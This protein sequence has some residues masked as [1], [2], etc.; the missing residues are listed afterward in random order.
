M[1]GLNKKRKE[2]KKECVCPD[3]V[4]GTHQNFIV[5]KSSCNCEVNCDRSTK[6]ASRAQGML[7]FF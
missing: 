1:T 3:L 6:N 7:L 2:K 5:S 4:V